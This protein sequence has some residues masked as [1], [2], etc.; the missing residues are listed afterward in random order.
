M[1]GRKAVLAVAWVAWALLTPL[2]P[3]LLPFPP[4]VVA[5]W[6]RWGG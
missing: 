3:F 5:A 4:L 6:K 1:L 2:G